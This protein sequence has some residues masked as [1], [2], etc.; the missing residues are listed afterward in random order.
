VYADTKTLL[1][2]SGSAN[3]TFSLNSIADPDVDGI[4]HQPAFHDKWATLYTNYRVIKT[5]WH[6]RF[7][8]NRAAIATSF[9]TTQAVDT[10]HNDQ[11]NLPGIVGYEINDSNGIQQF[12]AADMN[13]IRE[14]GWKKNCKFKMTTPNPNA[15]YSF[16]GTAYPKSY[17]DD[18]EKANTASPF[19]ANPS[20]DSVGYLHV[21]KLSKDGGSMASYRFDIRITYYVELTDPVGVEN[22][23]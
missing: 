18:P 19:G 7:M 10:S 6:I 13:V 15:T 5:S 12:E 22:E 4:G 17:L 8:P 3:H 16:S 9:A 2:N 1:A 23:N 21:C 20:A 11:F 14:V